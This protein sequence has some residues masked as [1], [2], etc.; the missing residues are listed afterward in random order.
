VFT[1]L[2]MVRSRCSSFI[3]IIC[4]TLMLTSSLSRLLARHPNV[5]NRLRL[6]IQSIVGTG[7]NARPPERG[8]LKKM[9]YLNL[10]LKEGEGLISVFPVL[11]L[12]TQ[13]YV[14]NSPTSIPLRPS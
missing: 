8:D 1:E 10:V 14:F 9:Q 13:I 5:F 6:E 2:D 7:I 4:G 12:L 11:H 3:L